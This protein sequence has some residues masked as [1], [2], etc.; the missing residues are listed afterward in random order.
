MVSSSC[1]CFCNSKEPTSS[2]GTKGLVALRVMLRSC[3]IMESSSCMPPIIIM[4]SVICGRY[5]GPGGSPGHVEVLLDHGELVLHAAH[6][7]HVL[8]HLRRLLHHHHH[9]RRRRHHGSAHHGGRRH[10]R[11]HALHGAAL[12]EPPVPHLDL[13]QQVG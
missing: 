11:V 4:S 3:S 2:E 12:L 10:A 9:L 13:A 5:K 7:H 1:T 6:H 8:G